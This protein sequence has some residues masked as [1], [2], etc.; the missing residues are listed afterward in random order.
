MRI[1]KEIV[2]MM[3]EDLLKVTEKLSDRLFDEKKM[4]T[5]VKSYASA[6]ELYQTVKVL[7]QVREYHAGQ[8]RKGVDK[9]P[10]IYHP[11][12][13]ACHALALGFDEDDLLSAALLHDVCEDCGVL[14]ENLP[15][16]DNTREAVRLLTKDKESVK[17]EEGLALYYRNLSENRIASIVK[18]LD[19][20]N[21]ISS[22][23]TSFTEKRMAQYITETERYI[24]PLMDKTANEYPEHSNQIFLIKYHMT[25]VIETI[26]HSIARNNKH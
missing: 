21:N 17:Q 4:Y 16:N 10:Y 19:R 3:D 5:Y 1:V 6:K 24:Y 22:M 23:S 25:S 2:L 11:L 26:R 7:P 13:L 9:V 8:V 14:L 20:C 15:V 12:L 18:L